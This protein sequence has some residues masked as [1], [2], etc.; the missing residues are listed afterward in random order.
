MGRMLGGEAWGGKRKAVRGK[1]RGKWEVWTTGAA[2]LHR[3]RSFDRLRTTTDAAAAASTTVLRLAASDDYG[4][5]VCLGRVQWMGGPDAAGPP[6]P[7]RGR[8][9]WIGSLSFW[10]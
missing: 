9:R 2:L 6:L 10:G 8:C 7:V 3:L 5:R 1:R 4:S